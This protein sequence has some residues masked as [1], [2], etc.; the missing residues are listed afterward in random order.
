MMT[1]FYHT[2]PYPFNPL[3]S[4][5]LGPLAFRKEDAEGQQQA[6]QSHYH[7]Y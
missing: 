7:H 4:L 2:L 6:Y 5:P 1:P 3:F